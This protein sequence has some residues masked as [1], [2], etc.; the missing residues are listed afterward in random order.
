MYLRTKRLEGLIVAAFAAMAGWSA[1]SACEDIAVLST[2]AR[3]LVLSGDT[4]EVRDVGN[5]WWLGIR[6]VDYVI[7]ES[8]LARAALWTDT[9]H[10]LETGMWTGSTS[11][12]VSLQDLGR[13]L[14][15]VSDLRLAISSS[16]YDSYRWVNDDPQNRLLRIHRDS[17][18]YLVALVRSDLTLERQWR[19]P[20]SGRHG[21][22]VSCVMDDRLFIGGLE[23]RLIA[24]GENELVVDPIARAAPNDGYRLG[25]VSLGCAVVLAYV[26][27]IALF[28]SS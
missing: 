21:S 20:L 6:G 8:T 3:Y 9:R 17:D 14:G 11:A 13:Q 24:D 2:D 7:P 22:G 28:R 1:A 10:D 26:E 4:L 15:S 12:L 19:S 27:P 16:A 25:S 5:L 23:N 18:E